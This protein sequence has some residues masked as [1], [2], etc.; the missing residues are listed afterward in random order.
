MNTVT[1]SE[2]QALHAVAAAAAVVAASG[3]AS[4]ADEAIT[5]PVVA[6]YEPVKPSHRQTARCTGARSVPQAIGDP[7]DHST[8]APLW[9]TKLSALS[10]AARSSNSAAYATTAACLCGRS[11]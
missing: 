2:V 10:V 8:K 3:S 9:H 6:P 1:H 5:V 7:F 11:T 4:G